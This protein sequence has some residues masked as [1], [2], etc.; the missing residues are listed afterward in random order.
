MS[1]E[2]A[3]APRIEWSHGRARTIARRPSDGGPPLL[4]PTVLIGPMRDPQTGRW[5]AGNV[6]HRVRAVR[7]AARELATLNPATCGPWLRPHVADGATY[8]TELAERFPDPALR[9]LVLDCAAA[10]TAYRALLALAGEGDGDALKEAR[11]W[12]REHR[13]CLATLS[14]LAGSMRSDAPAGLAAIRARIDGGSR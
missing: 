6:A 10:H 12:L 5:V 14:A 3:A 2:R 11:A 13:A 4:P 9:R 1:D 8:A 7:A